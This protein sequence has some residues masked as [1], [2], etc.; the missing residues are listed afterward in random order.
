MRGNISARA[1]YSSGG[2]TAGNDK[3]T[4]YPVC[5]TDTAAGLD[6]AITSPTGATV[7]T[8]SQPGADLPAGPA[9]VL[10]ATHGYT[11]TKSETGYPIGFT[12]HWDNFV[13]R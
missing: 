9:R 1:A 8:A 2:F 10:F 6:V 3:A 5:I 11:P 4:R 12:F 13:V 7:L